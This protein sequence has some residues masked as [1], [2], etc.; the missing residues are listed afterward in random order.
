MKKIIGLLLLAALF[1]LACGG[2]E[3]V[4]KDVNLAKERKD[5]IAVSEKKATEGI[6]KLDADIKEAFVWNLKQ[7]KAGL[8]NK[9]TADEAQLK[10]EFV[11]KIRPAETAREEAKALFGDAVNQRKTFENDLDTTELPQYDKYKTQMNTVLDKLDLSTNELKKASEEFQKEH[12][13]LK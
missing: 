5:F 12:K 1:T 9:D 4:K 6:T 13:K 2:G 7:I 11:K 8:K 10:L 3:V